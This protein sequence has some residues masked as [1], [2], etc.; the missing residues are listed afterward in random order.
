MPTYVCG[1]EVTDTAY[2]YRLRRWECRL[3]IVKDPIG[4]PGEVV[5]IRGFGRTPSLAFDLA[6]EVLRAQGNRAGLDD[7]NNNVAE[8][9]PEPAQQ[10]PEPPKYRNRYGGEKPRE[11][12]QPRYTSDGEPVDDVFEKHPIDAFDKMTEEVTYDKKTRRRSGS[13]PEK[14]GRQQ[15]SGPNGKRR[16]RKKKGHGKKGYHNMPVRR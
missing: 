8:H 3:T 12:R 16:R 4:D 2:S 11:P 13:V 9:H 1:Y 15:G 10:P 7:A 14:H 5:R 6:C